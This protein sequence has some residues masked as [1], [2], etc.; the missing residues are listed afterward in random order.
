MT[1]WFKGVA[2]SLPLAMLLFANSMVYAQG[3]D[4]RLN[5]YVKSFFSM[6]DRSFLEK[7]S[8]I[9][10]TTRKSGHIRFRLKLF[11]RIGD[12]LS[13]DAAYE[14]LPRYGPE[15]DHE[16]LF[17]STGQVSYRAD[18]VNKRI[19][20]EVHGEDAFYIY[21]D[22]D[23]AYVTLSVAAADFYMGRQPISFGSG[24]AVNPTDVITP[25]SFD[26]LDKE[27][28]KGVDALRFRAP[29]GEMGELDGGVIFGS[30]F[31]PE[32]SAAYLNTRFSVRETDYALMSM[33][34]R[35]NL[36]M[37]LDIQTS[38]KGAGYWL[39]AAYVFVGATG[40]KRPEEDYLRVSTG[41][42]YNLFGNLYAFIEYHF[43]GA[44]KDSAKDYLR[45]SNKTAYH[46]GQV[47][48]LSRHY[49]IPGFTC[50]L[51]PLINIQ[52]NIMINLT[53]GS[54]FIS[55]R[56]EYS[57]MQDLFVEVGGFISVGEKGRFSSGDT[58]G[59]KIPEARS[60]FG[61][62]QDLYFVSLRFYF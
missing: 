22:I 51:T 37:G 11:G 43:N 23:R 47:Y 39:E 21:Q 15:E 33:L 59:V 56:L 45:L 8:G 46:E 29:L 17:F 25:F 54:L 16:S 2:R 61:I 9:D 30:H 1:L 62:Y 44:G 7:S 31:K 41:L 38:L 48:L 42:D 12:N 13:L 52:T 26:A 19:H 3:Y 34:F 40:E 10:S 57:L 14:V 53:D 60:E 18:D 55:P 5:G 36:L 24:R 28:R 20:R 4:F 50:T 49:L 27:E 6:N 32:E 35:E 58:G